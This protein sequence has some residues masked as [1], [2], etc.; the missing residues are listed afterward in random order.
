MIT[1]LNRFGELSEAARNDNALREIH[2]LRNDVTW[3]QRRI[4]LGMGDVSDQTLGGDGGACVVGKLATT[5]S[6]NGSATLTLYGG[7][8]AGGIGSASGGTV[9][10]IDIGHMPGTIAMPTGQNLKATRTAGG[11]YIVEIPG[12]VYTLR[13]TTPAS[14]VATGA[15]GTV[16][17]ANSLGSPSVYNPYTASTESSQV[18]WVKW[19]EL[20]ARWEFVVWECP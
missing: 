9:S 18:C 14:P 10:V 5:L 11:L 17:L 15:S 20:S 12:W 6:R 16:V 19:N 2:S 3:L 4:P 1:P 13:G 8:A 7:A